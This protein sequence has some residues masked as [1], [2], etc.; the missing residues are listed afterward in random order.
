ME[1]ESRNDTARR[2]AEYSP[3][4]RSSAPPQ[5]R[6]RRRRRRRNSHYGVLVLILV[7]LAALIFAGV[8]VVK[9]VADAIFNAERSQ[10]VYQIG[11]T[12]AY[13]DG[14][15]VAAEQAPYRDTKGNAMVPLSS[16]CENLKLERFLTKIPRLR[17]K[18]AAQR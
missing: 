3:Q 5:R 6:R 13:L 8:R 10:L 2:R 7:L 16:L 14:K 17:S 15:S 1:Y 9:G 4:R 12:N 18:P 11:N